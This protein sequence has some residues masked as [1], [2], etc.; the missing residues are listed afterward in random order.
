MSAVFFYG[1]DFSPTDLPPSRPPGQD[2]ALLH[3]ESPKNEPIFNF[4]PA[5]RLFN[6]TST[7]RAASDLPLSTLHLRGLDAIVQQK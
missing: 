3:E 2:W 5:L 1:T 7:F 4:A 6:H